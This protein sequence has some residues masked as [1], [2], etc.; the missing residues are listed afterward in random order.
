MD[1][2]FWIDL[3]NKL[4]INKI[5][6]IIGPLFNVGQPIIFYIIK[7]LYFKPKNILSINNFNLPV[8]I[9][10]ILYFINLIYNYFKFLN[11][12]ILITSSE[13]GHLKWPWIDY[14]NPVFY[15]IL[16]GINIFYLMN[17]KYGL[18]FFI[19]TYLFLIL[20]VIYFSYNIGELWC[21]FGCFIPII[22]LISSY[23]LN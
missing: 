11:N 18:I 22:I 20:S 13:N 12:S 9:L 6:T 23:L 7:L 5:V 16:M 14:N 15:L 3:K 19:I 17:F 8:L 2:L 21:F 4:G 10:N 1:F